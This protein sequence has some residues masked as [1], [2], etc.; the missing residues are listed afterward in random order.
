MNGADVISVVVPVYNIAPYIEKCVFS[1]LQQTYSKI[2]I[3]MVDDG[4]TDGSDEILNRLAHE[5]A[6][7]KVIHQSNKGV[8]VAPPNLQLI[9]FIPSHFQAKSSD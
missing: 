8:T 5:Y 2:E 6:N 4:S 7:I 3:I 9:N 1:I